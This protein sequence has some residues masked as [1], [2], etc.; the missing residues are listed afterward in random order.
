MPK[1][2][3]YANG[4]LRPYEP[5]ASVVVFYV[6]WMR[7]LSLEAVGMSFKDF[8]EQRLLKGMKGKGAVFPFR[9]GMPAIPA[10][11]DQEWSR[12]LVVHR[13]FVYGMWGI[14]FI[15]LVALIGL[16]AGMRMKAPVPASFILKVW[17]DNL[18]P[19]FAP[20]GFAYGVLGTLPMESGFAWAWNRRCRR[21]KQQGSRG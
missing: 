11:E 19:T 6:L 18:L 4:P 1:I 13:C 21:L 3:S 14:P 17:L 15:V 20:M 7:A 12:K 8:H 2:S 9:I 5:L 16:A 10:S